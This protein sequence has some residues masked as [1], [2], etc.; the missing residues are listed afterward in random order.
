MHLQSRAHRGAQMPCLFCMKCF[1]TAGAVTRHLEENECPRA[2]FINRDKVY[3]IIRAKDPYGTI[4]KSLL[5]G[6]GSDQYQ[7]SGDWFW[8]GYAYEWHPYPSEFSQL[9]GHNQH[10]NSPDHQ[11]DQDLYH[12]P[13]RACRMDSK[14]LAGVINHLESET[15]GFMRL[16][17]VQMTMGNLLGNGCL[18]MF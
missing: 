6:Q 8:N 13:N 17:D 3:K 16:D 12:C 7:A 9:Q 14:T 11:E 4:S 10:L 15:C 1:A 2:P 5:S 18:P